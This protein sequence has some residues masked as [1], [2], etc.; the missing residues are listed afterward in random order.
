MNKIGKM[1][2]GVVAVAAVVGGCLLFFNK[3]VGTKS[4]DI[5]FGG[6]SVVLQNGDKTLNLDLPKA[7]QLADSPVAVMGFLNLTEE[8]ETQRREQEERMMQASENGE[9]FNEEMIDD[10]VSGENYDAIKDQSINQISINL[11]NDISARYEISNVVY[12]RDTLESIA[13]GVKDAKFGDH[14]FMYTVQT[15]DDYH[16]YYMVCNELDGNSIFVVL[17]AKTDLSEDT[18]VQYM[19]AIQFK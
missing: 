12:E 9:E 6:Q 11:K 2:I 8:Q 4:N 14:D 18:L 1:I 7:D 3:G 15:Q 17:T 5:T 19:S 16:F 13:E 10:T